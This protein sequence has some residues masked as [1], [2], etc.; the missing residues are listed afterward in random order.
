MILVGE[1][2][3]EDK[4][5]SRKIAIALI[6]LVIVLLG[7]VLLLMPML[8]E[9][10]ALYLAPGLGLKH[11]FVL[12]FFISIILMIVFAVAAGDGLIG[13]LQF[14]IPGFFLFLII[15]ALLLAWIF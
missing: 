6:A 2:D 15:I 1:I 12:S 4:N 9:I 10:S 8:A 3:N 7:A 11:A 5:E 14:V 13:E